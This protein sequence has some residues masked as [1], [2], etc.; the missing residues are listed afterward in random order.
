MIAKTSSTGG[1]V[2]YDYP[3]YTNDSETINDEEP[4]ASNSRSGTN[5]DC[6][7]VY[8]DDKGEY[9]LEKKIRT[10]DTNQ[11]KASTLG[12]KKPGHQRTEP[13][14]YDELDYE[15]SPRVEVDIET[16]E[17]DHDKT[18]LI[19]SNKKEG[20]SKQNKIMIVSVLVVCVV[21]AL[22]LAFYFGAIF[23]SQG[24]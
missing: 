3:E 4:K 11:T 5:N 16:R 23:G 13:N 6:E 7:H 19:D 20:L 15:L 18:I 9:V 10:K 2:Y 24:K 1:Y 14:I 12:N 17:V 8:D 21:G 22:F